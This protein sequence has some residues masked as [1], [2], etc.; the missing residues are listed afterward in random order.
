[1][2]QINPDTGIRMVLTDPYLPLSGPQSGNLINN[3]YVN[4]STLLV[5][6]LCTAIDNVLLVQSDDSP[7][8]NQYAS[9]SE[10]DS[11]T[12]L[13]TTSC[14]VT[15]TTTSSSYSPTMTSSTSSSAIV[16][17]FSTSILPTST[18]KSGSGNS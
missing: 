4:E 3:M 9:I 13:D 16:S 17:S 2:L 7:E 1:M 12:Q 10:G 11:L 5:I 14:T 6:C 18:T 8:L 15:P